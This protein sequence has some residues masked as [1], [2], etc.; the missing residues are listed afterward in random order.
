MA[1]LFA[2]VSSVPFL[3]TK[4]AWSSS[5]QVGLIKT[6]DRGEAV[7]RSLELLPLPSVEKKKILIKPNFN[8]AHPAPGSTHNDTLIALIHAL[9][10]RGASNIIIGERSGPPNTQEV[11]EE[12]GIFA[13]AHERGVEVVNFD[14]LERD[15]LIHFYDERLHWKNG[16]HV[17]RLLQEVDLCIATP[18]LKTHQYGGV[19]TMALKLAVGLIP[20][21]GNSYMQ[22][23]HSSQDMCK[24]IAEI[25]LAYNPDLY[26]VDGVEAF[27]RGGPS[28]GERVEAGVTLASRDRV[29]VDAV[30]LAVLKDLGTTQEI[31]ETPIFQQEQ[32]LWAQEL[33]LGLPHPSHL[34]LITDDREG[35][36]YIEKIGSIIAKG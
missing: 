15:A 25:N 6:F 1:Y 20:K 19:F 28:T 26:I 10:E 30:G 35:E 22:E 13:L 8:T 32:I 24:M 21:T 34:Q 3:S 4:K 14:T 7:R 23:L 27:I 31:M 2:G 36:E 29:A 17:P 9:W 12:K 11:M 18:C 16:F 33:G 5:S